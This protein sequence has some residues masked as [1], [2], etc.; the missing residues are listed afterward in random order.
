VGNIVQ[1]CGQASEFQVPH[2]ATGSVN[3]NTR[4]KIFVSTAQPLPMGMCGGPVFARSGE[5]FGVIDGVVNP[6]PSENSER[7]KNL[8]IDFLREIAGNASCIASEDV[9]QFLGSV[10]QN[11]GTKEAELS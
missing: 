10:E 3:I 1:D 8:D 11:F 9:V 7:G 2:V 6:P 4:Q 5:S